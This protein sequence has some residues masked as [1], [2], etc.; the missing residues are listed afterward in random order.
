MQ[1][2]TFIA[3]LPQIEQVLVGKGIKVPR[4]DYEGVVKGEGEGE[5]EEVVKRESGGK[6][7]HEATS[8]E[9]EA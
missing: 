5:E 3:L 1:Y 9:D 8:D 2:E 4:P 6:L 7:N